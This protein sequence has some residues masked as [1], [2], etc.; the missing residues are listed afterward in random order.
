MYK[1][2]QVIISGNNMAIINSIFLKMPRDLQ[3]EVLKFLRIPVNILI[4]STDFEYYKD[5]EDEASAFHIYS[6]RQN[7][8]DMF[9]KNTGKSF[10]SVKTR[11]FNEMGCYHY[12]N[13]YVSDLNPV[14]LNVKE[15]YASNFSDSCALH[16]R[17]TYSCIK[18]QEYDFAILLINV[19]FSVYYPEDDESEDEND[20]VFKDTEIYNE[21]YDNTELCYGLKKFLNKKVVVIAYDKYQPAIGKYKPSEHLKISYSEYYSAHSWNRTKEFYAHHG[22]DLLFPYQLLELLN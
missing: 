8:A 5:Y 13:E 1:F 11:S 3:L 10:E 20:A 18:N 4:A 22:Y 12:Y 2:I 6:I 7:V 14:K 17:A 9:F 21:H 16:E 15:I 19:S